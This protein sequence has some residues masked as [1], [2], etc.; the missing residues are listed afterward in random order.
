MLCLYQDFHQVELLLH[1]PQKKQCVQIPYDSRRLTSTLSSDLIPTIQQLGGTCGVKLSEIETIACIH[2][3]GS[4]TGLRITLAALQGIAIVRNL[5]VY[6]TSS[7]KV[8]AFK[9]TNIGTF[10]VSTENSKGAYFSQTFSKKDG[11]IPVTEDDIHMTQHCGVSEKID[12][13]DLY[14]LA[15]AEGDFG[16]LARLYA[17]YGHTPVFSTKS[18]ER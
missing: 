9:S 1:T 10:L 11:G 18:T 5:A 7:L 2:G 12:V 17:V 16:G 8:I 14:A 15:L 4:F 3:P 6:T 13:H